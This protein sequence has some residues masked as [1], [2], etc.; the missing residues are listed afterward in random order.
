MPSVFLSFAHE[1]SDVARQIET[2]LH[3][4]GID[5]FNF[6]A[7]PPGS[8]ISKAIKDA[9][10]SADSFIFLIS[11]NFARSAWASIEV[12]AAMAI[13]DT[14]HPKP[15]F[16]LLIGDDLDPDADLPSLLRRFRWL[17]MR[18]GVTEER[19]EP[20]LAAL[21]GAETAPSLARQLDAE[22]VMLD[23][24]RLELSR[25]RSA[26]QVDR[27]LLIRRLHRATLMS[28]LV[29]FVATLITV[30]SIAGL[31][32]WA[33]IRDVLGGIVGGFV[34]VLVARRYSRRGQGPLDG[35]RNG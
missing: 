35:G 19:L 34:G 24:Q 12:A 14:D 25:A 11:K 13:M 2:V 20:V 17:D 10:D 4:H 6:E 27:M 21:K 9:I 31:T 3:K 30:L 28:I 15:I 33:M 22:E 5:S 16:P 29:G 26:Y 7:I 8:N 18:A 32:E 1:D 23:L